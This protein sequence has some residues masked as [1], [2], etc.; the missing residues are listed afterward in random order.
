MLLPSKLQRNTKNSAPQ[1]S[2]DKGPKR[3]QAVPSHEQISF[4]AYALYQ[5]GGCADGRDQQDWFR[6]E[7]EIFAAGKQ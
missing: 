5:S 2:T 6:A 4:R 7:Q 1:T 3:G